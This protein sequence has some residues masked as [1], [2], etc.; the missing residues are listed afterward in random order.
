MIPLLAATVILTTL[1]PEPLVWST[2]WAAAVAES[3]KTGK[4]I[5]ANFTG[6]DWCGWC[7]K[8]S[9]EVFDYSAFQDWAKA[10]V[11]S[12]ELDYPTPAVKQSD[13]LKAQNQSLLRKYQVSGYPT[14]LFVDASGQELARMGYEKGG[15]GVWVAMAEEQL[16]ASTGP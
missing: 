4:P 11:I 9:D 13:S 7:H 2:D 5:M 12:V 6:S 3:K 15:P 14:L 8:L 16:R 10:R 1:P